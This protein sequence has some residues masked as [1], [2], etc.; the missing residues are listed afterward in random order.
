M[1]TRVIALGVT[2]SI[3]AYKAAELTS[4]LAKEGY[5]VHV[6]MTAAALKLVGEQTFLTLS[7]RPVVTSLWEI[8]DWK[9][10]HIDLAERAEL[11]LVAPCTANFMGKYA[12]GVA[13]DALTTFAISFDGK[14]LL[15]PAM[16]T[17]MWRHPATRCNKRTLESR[18]VVFAGPDAGLLACGDE[19]EGRMCE[20]QAILDKASRLL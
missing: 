5:E 20:V 16:N 19:G 14:V 8:P 18:G 15:A 13:D 3:A 17:R 1:K 11:L 7:R 10:G 4:Q 12:H 2:G 9:P 6:L